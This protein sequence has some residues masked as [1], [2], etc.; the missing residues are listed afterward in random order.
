VLIHVEP[1]SIFL[2]LIL[3]AV[4]GATSYFV[5][6]TWIEALFPQAKRPKTIKGK[7]KKASYAEV[8]AEPTSGNES[9]DATATGTDKAYDEQWIPAHNINRPV[10]KRVKSG[11]SSKSRKVVE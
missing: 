3:T 2:Y 9:A 11:A 6:K 5:Y 7:A 4:F 8:V 1:N 10:A